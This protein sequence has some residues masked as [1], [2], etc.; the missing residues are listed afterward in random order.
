[1]ND[2][3]AVYDYTANAGFLKYLTSH[4]YNYLK[5][6]INAGTARKKKKKKKK[7]KSG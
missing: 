3:K 7:K 1:M 2:D 6:R 4:I 5:Q